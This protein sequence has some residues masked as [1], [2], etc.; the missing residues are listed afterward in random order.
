MSA[1]VQIMTAELQGRRARKILHTPLYIISYSTLLN[2]CFYGEHEE[3]HTD[4]PA[5]MLC[6]FLWSVSARSALARGCP[7]CLVCRL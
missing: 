7:S 6:A 3:I 2:G 4:A 5:Y 1:W